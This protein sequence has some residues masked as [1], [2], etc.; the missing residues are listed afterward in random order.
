MKKYHRLTTAKVLNKR[1][2]RT[3]RFQYNLDQFVLYSKHSLEILKNSK[4]MFLNDVAN[5]SD[6]SAIN[7][8][9]QLE[10]SLDDPILQTKNT[11]NSGDPNFDNPLILN[12][13]KLKVEKSL[14]L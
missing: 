12:F 5:T 4:F 3:K 9:F 1:L 10:T 2:N 13:Y 6:H 8:S 14:V 7:Y 11:L